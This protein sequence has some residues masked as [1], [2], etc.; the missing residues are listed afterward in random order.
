M[1][2]WTADV[3]VGHKPSTFCLH[4][5]QAAVQDLLLHLELGDAIAQKTADTVAALIDR[6]VM[7]GP[8]ELLSDGKPG[9]PRANDCHRLTRLFGGDD[10]FDP[11]F[12]PGPLDD[13]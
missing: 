8:C 13:R 10:R 12:A 9:R 2:G 11:A 6:H 7:T 4:L 5:L 1:I 3:S